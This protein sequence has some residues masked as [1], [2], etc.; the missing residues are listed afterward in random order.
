MKKNENAFTGLE[1]A[2]VLIAFVVV[3][4]VFSYVMLGAGFF[5]AQKAQDVVHSGIGQAASSIEVIGDVYGFE[6][7]TSGNGL[8]TVQFTIALTSGMSPMNI[9]AMRVTYADATTRTTPQYLADRAA[10]TGVQWN[11]TEIFDEV[12][13]D[14]ILEPGEKFLLTVKVPDTPPNMRFTISMQPEVGALL[15]VVRT[16]PA[17]IYPVNILR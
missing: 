13:E 8:G 4:A 11:I 15:T 9:S 3:A 17:S 16:A 14:T 6:N 10:L 2:I 12:T 1:A 5:T 7:T